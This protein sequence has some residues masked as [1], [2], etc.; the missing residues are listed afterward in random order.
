MQ[1]HIFCFVPDGKGGYEEPKEEKAPESY[2]T[3]IGM[4]YQH[5]HVCPFVHGTPRIVL[6]FCP[7]SSITAVL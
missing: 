6:L 2:L 7:I 1:Q 5:L 4:T 3:G